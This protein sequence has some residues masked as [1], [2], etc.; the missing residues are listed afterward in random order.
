[1]IEHFKV[2]D[3]KSCLGEKMAV[4]KLGEET[5]RTHAI[6]AVAALKALNM[7]IG[8]KPVVQEERE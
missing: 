5:T 1:M 7:I 6:G 2:L 3:G 8:K 4:R